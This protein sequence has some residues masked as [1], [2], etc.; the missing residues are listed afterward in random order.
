MSGFLSLTQVDLMVSPLL[1]LNQ[2]AASV[3]LKGVKHRNQVQVS[4]VSSSNL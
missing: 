2:P 4:G 3:M 1:P